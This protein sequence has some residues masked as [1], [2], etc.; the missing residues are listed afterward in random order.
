MKKWN[1]FFLVLLIIVFIISVIPMFNSMNSTL[2][3]YFFSSAMKK[4]STVYMPILLFGMVEWALLMLYLQSLLKD[5][6]RQDATKFDL[7]K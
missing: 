7:D 5:I 6:K 4:F 3:V 1:L 2:T